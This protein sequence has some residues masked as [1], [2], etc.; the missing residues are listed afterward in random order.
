MPIYIIGASGHGKIVLDVL[1]ARREFFSGDTT[2]MPIPELYTDKIYF[3]DQNSELAGRYLNGHEILYMKTYAL[4]N[5][6]FFFVAIG[7]NEARRKIYNELKSRDYPTDALASPFA[8]VSP[9]AAI[10]N[11]TLINHGVIVQPGVVIGENCII[12]TGVSIDHD[13]KISSHVHIAPGSTLCG[14]VT[15]GEGTFI[16]AGSI[17]RPGT[18]IGKNCFIQMGSIVTQNVPDNTTWKLVYRDNRLF[19][20]LS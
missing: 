4:S 3:A 1:K 19:G 13:S 11:G 20:D 18:E 9:E 5:V 15:I 10:G 12:N 7:D 8:Y 17:I 16:G 14:N 2:T 6:N